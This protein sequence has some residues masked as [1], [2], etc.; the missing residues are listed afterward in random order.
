MIISKG[1]VVEQGRNEE[2][3]D[4]VVILRGEKWGGVGVAGVGGVFVRAAQCKAAVTRR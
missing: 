2:N 3:V 4:V 1:I